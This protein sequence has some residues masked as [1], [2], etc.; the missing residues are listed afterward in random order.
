MRVIDKLTN[1]VKR[2]AY[3]MP[4]VP[5]I[6]EP[7]TGKF[8]TIVGVVR[9]YLSEGR[10]GQLVSQ[11]TDMFPLLRTIPTFEYVATVLPREWV[12][13]LADAAEVKRIYPNRLKYALQYPTV[14]PEAIFQTEHGAFK[15][16]VPF[17]STYYTKRLIGADKAHQ[18]GFF[19]SGVRVAVCDTGVDRRHPATS[20]MALDSVMAQVRDEN[21]HGEW[22]CACVGGKYAEDSVLS[23]KVG[24][25]IPTEGVAPRASVVGIKCLGY[26]IGTGSDDAV[27]KAIELAV[28]RYRVDI[29]SMSLGGPVEESK[30]EEDPYYKV[31]KELTQYGVIF[32]VAAGNEGPAEKT[33]STPGW[34]EDVLTVGAYD[35]ITG[36]LADFSSRGPTADGRTKPDCVAPGVNIHAPCTGLLD[37]AGDN[38]ALNNYSPLSGTSMSTPHVSGLLALMREA[39]SKTIGRVLTTDEVKKMLEALGHEK[40]NE[41]GWGIITWDMYEEWMETQY[42]VR[43]R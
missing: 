28:H 16:L 38:T 7:K 20:H 26:L 43:L 42:G 29:V 21:G 2:L 32:S 9:G 30:Q 3:R 19:G 34:L 36:K 1:T 11:I 35:P 5:I 15:E 14:P 27:L 4:A 41:D 22:C 39:H 13:D 18:K 25:K 24:R 8:D 37:R 40:T 31:I 23:R 10:F 12:F 6:I 33:I 17:T